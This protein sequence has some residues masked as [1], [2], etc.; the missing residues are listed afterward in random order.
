MKVN[1]HT[2][3]RIQVVMS[4]GCRVESDFLDATC[5]QPYAVEIADSLKQG[6][7]AEPATPAKDYHFCDKHKKA[8]DKSML[9]FVMDE[10]LQEVIAEAQL[11]PVL[12]QPLPN[13]QPV[14]RDGLE[15]ENV[16]RVATI[17][18]AAN[19]P[20]RPPGIKT[21]S[22]SPEQLK[23][24]GSVLRRPLPARQVAPAAPMEDIEFVN[25]GATGSVASLD[26]LLDDH[27]PTELRV[28]G[29]VD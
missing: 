24:A 8:S 5:K 16:S 22:R 6:A 9:E 29:G 10:R 1:R 4:C 15:G 28:A 27:D 14:N 11:P 13:A 26:A 7:P 18:G 3:Y 23:Q 20:R 17:P 21:I 12:R 2:L 19:R 25:T